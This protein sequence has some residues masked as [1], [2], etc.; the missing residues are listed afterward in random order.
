MG[1]SVPPVSLGRRSQVCVWH[2]W[3]CVA[4]WDIRLL[5]FRLLIPPIFPSF[6]YGRASRV[7]TVHTF[8]QC[9]I[10]L[11][12]LIPAVN[13]NESPVMLLERQ[14]PGIFQLSHVVAFW[15][16]APKL[17]FT[18]RATF[19]CLFALCCVLTVN[20]PQQ[21]IHLQRLKYFLICDF[22]HPRVHV[23]MCLC[24][25]VCPDMFFCSFFSSVVSL[26]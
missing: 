15:L 9:S 10:V 16:I 8:S 25:G 4:T 23:N 7:D 2:N 12:M 18:E 13:K 24:P 17:V 6:H 21:S 14:F 20:L 19:P 3:A 11:N 26:C 5:W 1:W 22:G